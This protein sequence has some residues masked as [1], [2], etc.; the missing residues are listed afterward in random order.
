MDGFWVCVFFEGDFLFPFTT[1]WINHTPQSSSR[2]EA[3]IMSSSIESD[4]VEHRALLPKV[5]DDSME[6]QTLGNDRRDLGRYSTW[7]RLREPDLPTNEAAEAIDARNNHD[8][9]SEPAEISSPIDPESLRYATTALLSRYIP[10]ADK[11]HK[12]P[13]PWYARMGRSRTMLA[14]QMLLAVITCSC[15][16]AFLIWAYGVNAPLNGIGTLYE[17]SCDTA[18]ALNTGAHVVLNVFSSL[19]LGAGNYC[20]QVLV[21]PSRSQ[22]RKA[23]AL[24]G[25]SY[26]IG[27]HSLHNLRQ[28]RLS[29]Q[30]L[31][32]GLCLCSTLL[33]FT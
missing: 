26:D 4:E 6:M 15:N 28:V 5:A 9:T 24:G 32:L 12:R 14:M 13:K 10:D 17:G 18:G 19:F 31:W 8:I 2:S 3:S 25:K 16:I 1:S 21:A 30:L 11:H 23:S 33:H 29:K 22:V 27:V 7:P 20:M